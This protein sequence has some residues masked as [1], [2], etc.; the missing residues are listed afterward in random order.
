M[1]PVPKTSSLNLKFRSVI[2]HILLLF[3]V[4]VRRKMKMSKMKERKSKCQRWIKK[5]QSQS[6]YDW[7]TFPTYIKMFCILTT[8]PSTTEGQLELL[9]KFNSMTKEK[10]STDRDRAKNGT[11]SVGNVALF[12]MRGWGVG[13][14]TVSAVESTL[15]CLDQS[16]ARTQTPWLPGPAG[17]SSRHW[18]RCRLHGVWIDSCRN[19]CSHNDC[20]C[21]CPIRLRFTWSYETGFMEYAIDWLI[22]WLIFKSHLVPK[23]KHVTTW[24]PIELE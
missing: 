16:S 14:G 5:K 13:A 23:Q 18:C 19:T 2:D 4:Y 11:E 12:G 10:S 17:R 24:L 20:I 15:F 8:S 3:Q 6:I 1:D 9:V 22:D 21:N 7:D